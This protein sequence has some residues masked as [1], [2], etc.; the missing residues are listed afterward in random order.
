[1]REST[2]ERDASLV[3]DGGVDRSEDSEDDG[4]VAE[5]GG[6][7]RVDVYGIDKELITHSGSGEVTVGTGEG[8]VG[9]VLEVAYSEDDEI[10][11]G[12]SA[13]LSPEQARELAHDLQEGAEESERKASA[14]L[15]DQNDNG[16]E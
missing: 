4:V 12:A 3:T 5:E 8:R 13:V 15:D 14:F 6:L 9:V 16:E 7:A 10:E 2:A 1:M 11:V